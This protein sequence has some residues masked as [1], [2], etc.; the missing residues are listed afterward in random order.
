MLYMLMQGEEEIH[1]GIASSNQM[2]P[3]SDQDIYDPTKY[4]MDAE[5]ILPFPLTARIS[6]FLFQ[7]P[8]LRSLVVAKR[9]GV[10]SVPNRFAAE[11][12]AA[13]RAYDHVVAYMCVRSMKGIYGVIKIAGPVPPQLPHLSHLPMTPEFPIQWMRTIR[14]SM[15]TTAQLKIGQSGMFVGRTA[16]DSK[17]ESK[18]GSEI[19]YISYR[20]PVWDWM[21]EDQYPLAEE[22]MVNQRLLHGES[23]PMLPP[24]AL[25]GQDWVDTQLYGERRPQV[26]GG[27][28][29]GG[30]QH[31]GG[32]QQMARPVGVNSIYKQEFPGFLVMGSGPV[33]EE[34]FGRLG[35]LLSVRMHILNR[36]CVCFVLYSDYLY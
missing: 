25:F 15:R 28:G 5:L 11:I 6:Y 3:W 31:G 22:Y 34:M 32:Q 35:S 14:I 26:Y 1:E 18:V 10:W 30:G 8:D 23:P 20:K 17:F 36:T 19:M 2:D 12:N 21:A 33:A 24:D 13:L 16:T 29:G 27:G 9:R 4:R 7:A